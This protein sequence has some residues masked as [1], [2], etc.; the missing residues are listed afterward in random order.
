MKVLLVMRQLLDV[1]GN[2][3]YCESALLPTLKRFQRL[4]D[5]S[6]CAYRYEGQSAMPVD[7][8]VPINKDKVDFLNN[9]KSLKLRYIDRRYNRETLERRIKDADLVVGYV[10]GTVCDLALD[11][12]HRMGKKYLSF[13][14]ACIWDGTW[15]HANWKARLMAPIFFVETRRTIRRSDYA[16]Y[17]TEQFLQQRYPTRGLSLGC[18]DTSIDELDEGVLERRIARIRQHAGPL[19]LLTVGHLDVGFKG[20]QFVI[21]AMADLPQVEYYMIGAGDGDR[22]K[23]LAEQKGVSDRIHFLGKMNRRDVLRVMDD[24]D[25]YVQVSLQEGLP[26]SVAEAMSRAMPVVGS[27]TGGIPEMIDDAYIT[28]RKSVSDIVRIVGSFSRETLEQ[29][30]TR[31][32]RQARHYQPSELERKIDDFFTLLQKYVQGE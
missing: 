3:V 25:V 2:D 13:V 12:A 19:K 20:Q 23:R 9:E 30:A 18:T 24:M 26:R 32:F 16:W 29:E 22:L 7:M 28:R 17:V 4:G 15:H 31:N 27:R 1:R 5:L 8:L 14:V 21:A 6:I 11:I 10:P